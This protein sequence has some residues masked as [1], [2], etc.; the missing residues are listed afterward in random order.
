MTVAVAWLVIVTSS[1]S[2]TISIEF[3]AVAITPVKSDLAL[4]AFALSAADVLEVNC[5]ASFSIK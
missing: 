2:R 4:I 1:K 3:L 5:H